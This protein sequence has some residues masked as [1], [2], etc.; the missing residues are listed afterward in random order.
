VT[1]A[2]CTVLGGC[3]DYGKVA[4]TTLGNMGTPRAGAKDAGAPAREVG[5][6]APVTY[7]NKARNFQF[8]IPA[9]WA[10]VDGDPNSDSAQ[11]R[12]VGTSRHF[13]FHYT[14][15]AADFP[16]ETSVK[17]SLKSATDEVKQGTNLS[18]KRRDDRC[19][20]DPKKLCARGWELVDSG[21]Q[22]PQ[23]IIWQAYDTG[24]YYFNFMASA[25]ASEFEPAR[26]EL[27]GIIDS[28]KFGS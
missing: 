18:A 4:N 1:V 21:K 25:E 14:A 20:S 27:Q 3:A 24:N 23:R 7:G 19:A 10:K 6:A 28:I 2:V 26:S 12:K 11:F 8:T 16:A 17:A 5:S 22:G 13:N 15:M 9:G